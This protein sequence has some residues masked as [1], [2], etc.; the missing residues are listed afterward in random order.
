MI[1]RLILIGFFTAALLAPLPIAAQIDHVVVSPDITLQLAGLLAADEDAASDDLASNVVLQDIGEIPAN[2]DL[3][4][5]HLLDNDDRLLAFDITVELPGGLIAQPRDVVRYDG[6]NYSIVFDGSA[7]GIPAGVRLDALGADADGDLLMSFDTTLALSGTT[8]ADEDVVEFDGANFTLLFD[9]SAAGV[10]AGAD[11]DAL[12]FD[13]ASGHLFLSFDVGGVVG[14]T[15]FNDEDLLEHD[16][17]GDA[18]SLAYDGS[19]EHP[20]WVAGDLDAAFVA[21]LVGV[22]FSDGFENLP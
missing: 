16:P 17:V 20:A 9:G 6:V 2:A 21:F 4:V 10:P 5:Y 18:W 15:N 22:I 3:A 1:I 14:G 19:A 12:H 11:L 7:E 13:V 8:V